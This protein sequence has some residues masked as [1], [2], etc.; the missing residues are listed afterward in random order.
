MGNNSKVFAV[1]SSMNTIKRFDDVLNN[2]TESGKARASAIGKEYSVDDGIIGKVFE[3]VLREFIQPFSKRNNERVT[4]SKS[5]YGDLRLGNTTKIEIKSA[6]GELGEGSTYSDILPK[7]DLVIYCPEVSAEIPV[8]DQAFVFTRSDFIAMLEGYNG[9]G[10]AVR[11]GKTATNG[12]Q[13]IAIQ[14]FYAETRKS[15]SKKIAA[16]LWN[17]CY[18]HVTVSEWLA[19]KEG[20]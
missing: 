18:N 3:I 20:E 6:C 17:E 5:T 13:K 1:R 11:F 19:E 7:A 14:S 9:R 16:H 8:Q 15:A 4:P 10:S 2:L 12:A